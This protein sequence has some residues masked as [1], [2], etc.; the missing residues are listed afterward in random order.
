MWRRCTDGFP[1]EQEHTVF[2]NSVHVLHVACANQGSVSLPGPRLLQSWFWEGLC[3]K[4]AN[5]TPDWSLPLWVDALGQ[6]LCCGRMEHVHDVRLCMCLSTYFFS[7]WSGV[8]GQISADR[9]QLSCQYLGRE[10]AG[11]ILCR[12]SEMITL[13][14]RGVL[15]TPMTPWRGGA[16]TE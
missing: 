7:R 3:Y 8:N 4:C 13:V 1:T 2:V 16:I 6:Y 10:K 12:A 5:G 9:F 15:Y 11:K 14:G